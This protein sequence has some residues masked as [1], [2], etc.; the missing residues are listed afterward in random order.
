MRHKLRE[1]A[2][3]VEIQRLRKIGHETRLAALRKEVADLADE[4]KAL[5]EL[6]DRHYEG[7]RSFIPLNAIVG[8]LDLVLRRKDLLEAEVERERHALLGASRTLD[9]VDERHTSEKRSV[10]RAEGA[11]ALEEALPHLIIRRRSS[12]P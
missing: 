4:Q 2:R 5:E 7:G 8:R 1:L 3:L 12:L 11:R 6:Q 10:E 9:R